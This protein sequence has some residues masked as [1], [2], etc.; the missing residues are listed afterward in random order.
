MQMDPV[1][2]VPANVYDLQNEAFDPY[3]GGV[4]DIANQA[5]GGLLPLFGAIGQIA[6]FQMRQLQGIADRPWR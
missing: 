6:S 2:A 3:V 4:L 5:T 1:P